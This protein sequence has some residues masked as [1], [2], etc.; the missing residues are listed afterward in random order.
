MTQICVPIVSKSIAEAREQI[1]TAESIGADILEFW[2]GEFQ[3]IDDALVTEL[4]NMTELPVIVNC[5]GEDEKGLFDGSAREK[6]L[7]LEL[8]AEGGADYID[9]DYRFPH[10]KELKDHKMQL[11]LSAH[12]FEDTPKLEELRN[13]TQQ[14]IDAGADVVKFA[15]QPKCEEDVQL[16][17]EFALELEANEI[18]HICISMDELGQVTR[19]RSPELGNEI[20]FATV[21]TPTAPGQMSVAELQS[22]FA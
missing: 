3:Y 12:F 11:I 17:V 2:V 10:I 9:V 19:K 15:A 8:A 16:M 13:I 5:K 14:M 18:P 4:I 7:V 6:L 22:W 1:D 21:G 20:M